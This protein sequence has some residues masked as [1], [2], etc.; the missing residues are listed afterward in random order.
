MSS[1]N[2]DQHDLELRGLARDHLFEATKW[3]IECNVTEQRRDD[4]EKLI[5]N[6]ERIIAELLWRRPTTH[7]TWE[8]L[9]SAVCTLA[10]GQGSLPERTSWALVKLMPLL[11]KEFPEELREDFKAVRAYYGMDITDEQASEIADKIVHF[12]DT[13]TRNYCL[14]ESLYRPEDAESEG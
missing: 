9:Y 4:K 7:T 3:M 13:V 14:P 8:R 10:T 12:Y 5:K 11:V 1:E 6:L 2:T